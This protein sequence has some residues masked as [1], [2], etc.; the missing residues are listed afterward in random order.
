MGICVLV[1]YSWYYLLVLEA[2]MTKLEEL[3]AGLELYK[4]AKNKKWCKVHDATIELQSI[5]NRIREI[6]KE[7]KELQKELQLNCKHKWGYYKKDA[8]YSW[9]KNTAGFETVERPVVC[10]LC[11][12]EGIEIWTL[13]AIIIK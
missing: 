3:K 9:N 1:Y 11:G 12:I 5:T 6:E 4:N 7:I 10:K 2:I 13:N 8:W